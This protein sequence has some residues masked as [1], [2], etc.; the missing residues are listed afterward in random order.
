MKQVLIALGVMFL[1]G[2]LL[3]GGCTA[4]FLLQDSPVPGGSISAPVE[5]AVGDEF[6]MTVTVTNPNDATVTLDSIDIYY[7]FLDGFQV[8]S[9]SPS[10]GDTTDFEM[11]DFRSWDFGNTIAPGDE[12]DIVYKLRAIQPGH[13]SGDVD[14]CNPAQDFTT[15]LADIVVSGDG[16]TIEN[17]QGSITTPGSALVPG[18]SLSAP[19]KVTVGE[20]FD[21]TVTVTNPNS[22]SVT[23][24][25]ID[26]YHEFLEGFELIS[27]EPAA[28][29][30][31]DYGTLGFKS[32]DYGTELAAGQ[33]LD[34][35]YKFRAVKPG[36][37]SGDVDICNPQQDFTTVVAKIEVG[38]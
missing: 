30:S 27:V 3:I 5:V 38:N 34:I 19:A 17:G 7:S 22:S 24:D 1:L 11:L 28:K 15:V 12:L 35:V 18:G 25:S 37:Y 16:A 4:W 6:E 9:V 33:N 20:E 8:V 29:D 14:I 10:P 13:Y 21:M 26:I 2:C 31:T 32:W 23:L 36:S